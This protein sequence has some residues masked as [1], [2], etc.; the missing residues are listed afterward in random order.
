[1][2]TKS[3]KKE[4]FV[5]P[6]G[7]EALFGIIDRAIAGGYDIHIMAVSPRF[8]RDGD[9]LRDEPAEAPDED[10]PDDGAQ[11][12][13]SG[14]T[15]GEERRAASVPVPVPAPKKRRPASPAKTDRKYKSRQESL[16]LLEERWKP[17]M[18]SAELCEAAG[19]RRS[20]FDRIKHDLPDY[21]IDDLRLKSRTGGGKCL[22]GGGGAGDI[23]P[24]TRSKEEKAEHR[25]RESQERLR[26]N[27]YSSDKNLIF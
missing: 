26:V 9:C 27:S 19:V 14:G 4:L 15:A 20:S 11:P 2:K 10:V 6:P 7:E 17:G 22:S 5:Y 13:D 3:E 16:K 24:A 12:G 8:A 18:I 1:M 21:I 25:R 23:R